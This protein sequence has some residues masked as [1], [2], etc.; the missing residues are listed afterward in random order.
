[1]FLCCKHVDG[2]DVFKH[3]GGHAELVWELYC[4]CGDWNY[5]GV[6]WGHVNKLQQMMHRIFVFFWRNWQSQLTES[7]KVVTGSHHQCHTPHCQ[8]HVWGKG[9][10]NGVFGSSPGCRQMLQ[11]VLVAE[12][13]LGCYSEHPWEWHQPP[14]RLRGAVGALGLTGNLSKGVSCLLWYEAGIGSNTLTSTTQHKT[15]QERKL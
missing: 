15:S 7:Y 5:L 14:Q 10:R 3:V 2:E 4:R 1:M 8:L 12:E 13:A 9:Q 6:K 11:G